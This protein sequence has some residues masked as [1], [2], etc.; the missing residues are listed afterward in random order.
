M[1]NVW[2]RAWD[3]FDAEMNSPRREAASVI[4]DGVL[5]SVGGVY[6]MQALRTVERYSRA[7]NVW[8]P[9][10]SMLLQR[11][12]AAC[13]G[14]DGKLY[15]AGGYQDGT[16]PREGFL[17]KVFVLTPTERDITKSSAMGRWNTMPS[18]STARGGACLCAMNGDLYLIGG[19]NA[20]Q[21]GEETTFALNTGEKFD[22]T[23]RKWT[24]IAPMHE[25]RRDFSH[26]VAGGKLYVKG[27]R[28]TIDTNV[29]T[30]EEYDPKTNEW[31]AVLRV[32][33]GELRD[34][35]KEGGKRAMDANIVDALIADFEHEDLFT[36]GSSGVEGLSGDAQRC[37]HLAGML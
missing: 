28:S 14:L 29:H 36:H 27:G 1:Y 9:V 17:K 23:T 16:T 24:K 10:A 20:L 30:I 6:G 31:T 2:S 19:G 34:F 33:R 18:A 32:D 21:A 8:V 11:R 35:Q 26:L 3:K 12:G 7:K 5:Y 15:V 13:C 22:F 37:M 25:A 4:V